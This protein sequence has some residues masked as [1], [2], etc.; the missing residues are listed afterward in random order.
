MY[1]IAAYGQ[2]IA[3]SGRMAAYGEALRQCIRPGSA[4]LDIGSGTGIFAL[5]ACQFGARRV[6]AVEPDNAIQVAREIAAA[7]GY[8]ERIHFIQ[9]RSTAVTLPE[10]MDVVVSDLRGV[11]PPFQNHLPSI[12]DARRRLLG[13]DGVL[14]PR[15]DKLWATVVEAPEL[16]GRHLAGCDRPFDGLDMDAAR[17]IVVNGWRKARVEPEQ[18]LVEPKCW[19]TINYHEI[20]T[21]HVGGELS[22]TVAR[23]GIGHGL[24]LWFDSILAPG[25][26]LSNS[27]TLP[28]LIYGS[29]FFPWTTPAPLSGGDRVTVKLKATLVGA[30]YIW[31]WDTRIFPQESPAECKISFRQS[32]FFAAPL[33]RASLRLRAADYVPAI[34]DAGR[35]DRF[36]LE[37]MENEIALGEIA[38]RL[39]ARFPQRFSDWQRAL[40]HVA[41]LAQKYSSQTA[42]P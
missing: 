4:V 2:M 22:W 35:A 16:Y 11:L 24:L 14:I 28:E 5:L 7:N 32:T 8:A 17:R 40:D 36:V 20:A 31:C 15:Q 41:D 26:T 10:P 39:A 1:S 13:A 3:D 19:A 34:T 23:P 42:T 27:P 9:D 18:W 21:P 30:D 33:S 38:E 29:A 12:I 6:Y 25:V 37:L